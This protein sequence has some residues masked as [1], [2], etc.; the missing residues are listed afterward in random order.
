[1]SRRR[2]ILIAAAGAV[3]LAVGALMQVS[4]LARVASAYKA[5]T[6]CSEVYLAGRDRQTVLDADFAGISPAIDLAG[7]RF[8][9]ERTAVQVALF[10][11]GPAR[12]IYRE[13][14]GCT[15]ESRGEPAPVATAARGDAS[16]PWPEAKFSEANALSRVDYVALD[17]AL[18]AAFADRAAGHRAIVVVVDGAV[19]GE[20]YAPGFDAQTPFL[21][22]SMA[23]SVTATIAG[24]AA[25][26]GLLEINDPA[27]VREWKD[28]DV[29]RAITWN[30]LLRMQSGLAFD[31]TYGDPH[32]D[33]TQMLFRAR[34]AG[35]VAAAQPAEYAPGEHWSYSSGT[36]NLLARILAERLTAE[37]RSI[38]QFAYEN[39]F[40][41]IGAPSFVLETDSAGFP[42]GSSYVY[43]TARDWARLGQLYLNDG[44]AGDQ[45]ILPE[46]WSEYVSTPTEA[47][48]G[49]YGAHFWLNLDGANGRKRWVPG[50]PEDVYSMAGHEGQYVFIIPDAQMVVVRTGQTR[51]AVP[52]E[53]VGPVVSEIRQAVAAR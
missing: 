1:M 49:E 46:G 8:D 32:S 9:D 26:A 35:G 21:S 41:P 2:L 13:G 51:G 44:V 37:G 20:R 34:E 11:L 14:V 48:D 29:R 12:A 25:K 17:V 39:V 28:G 38:Q 23:K 47:S 30:D 42:I 19:V 27:P 7:V 5:K 18:D 15:V 22:W 16:E 6:L 50:L 43:A 53:V 24:A 52:I 31:E 3:L 36:T 33:V 10:G 45:R 40:A 4:S